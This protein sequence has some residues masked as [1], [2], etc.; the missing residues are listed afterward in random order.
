[1]RSAGTP[2]KAP[3]LPCGASPATP[4]PPDLWGWGGE[5]ATS[6]LYLPLYRLLVGAG[7]A[8][9]HKAPSTKSI[10]QSL[11]YAGHCTGAFRTAAVNAAG[12]PRLLRVHRE[13]FPSTSLSS[14][15]NP[16][17]CGQPAPMRGTRLGR[18]A[19]KRASVPC[20]VFSRALVS[21]FLWLCFL[22][23][24]G[25]NG[26]SRGSCLLGFWLVQRLVWVWQRESDCSV[27]VREVG[28]GGAI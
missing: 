5:H 24:W 2:H 11:C 26:G 4:H 14:H 16:L 6:A 13:I 3:T 22:V 12:Y 8:A 10:G 27:S 7:G 23:L 18:R 28:E 19:V 17:Y 1:M 20:Q 25:Y 9:R 21:G 15:W